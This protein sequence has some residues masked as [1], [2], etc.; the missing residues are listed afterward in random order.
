MNNQFNS[1]FLKLTFVIIAIIGALLFGSSLLS[2]NV[3]MNAQDVAWS[4]CDTNFYVGKKIFC[5]FQLNPNK[6]YNG[7]SGGYKVNFENSNQTSTCWL[8]SKAL[9]C[10][11]IPTDVLKAGSNKVI[12]QLDKNETVSK[13]VEVSKLLNKGVNITHWFRYGDKTKAN[14]MDYIS[15]KDIINVKELGFD[16][17]RLPIDVNEFYT[18]SNM[19]DYLGLAVKKIT[20]Q[21]LI[22]IV[23]GHSESLNTELETSSSARQKYK[24]FWTQLSER[25][26]GFDYKKVY[27]EPY[28]EPV[29]EN[30]AKLWSQ[31]QLELH[32]VIRKVLPDNTIVLTANNKSYSNSFADIEL[33]KDSNIMLDIHYY[34]EFVYTHQGADFSSKFL[35]NVSGLAYP[36][37]K[38]N[39]NNVLNSQTDKETKEKVQEYC[40]NQTNYDK[41]KTL[42]EKNIKPLR[43]KGYKVI[44]GEYGAF[45]CQ[46]N[47]SPAITKLIKDSKL[48]YL[49]D[50]S[51]IFTELNIPNTLWGYDD[52]FGLD[53]KKVNGVF[54]YDKD[55]L[56]AILG[57]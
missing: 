48:Q 35:Q 53:A 2:K 19:Y 15:D 20:D 8:E 40:N 36:F 18:N 4:Y 17:I 22:V 12:V 52:C 21:G 28:N 3:K 42:I 7:Q 31:F 33:P 51:K 55:Y 45:S 44:I 13:D 11:D 29:F 27:I 23:D 34:S 6:T 14:Y 26:K 39:C 30:N 25:L 10:N 47:T 5:R 38:L 49:K 54:E 56:D 16:H 32:Q 9:V 46:K 24:T 43:D 37:N 41:Q 57:K 1:T 50:V